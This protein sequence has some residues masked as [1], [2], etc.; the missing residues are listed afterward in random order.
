MVNTQNKNSLSI[1]RLEKQ[2]ETVNKKNDLTRL[3]VGRFYYKFC[4]YIGF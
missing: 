3:R 4:Y 1:S 2:N